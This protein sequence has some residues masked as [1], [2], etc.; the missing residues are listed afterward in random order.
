MVRRAATRTCLRIRNRG[1]GLV[2]FV[3]VAPTLLA[4][5]MAALQYGMVFHARFSLN[6]AAFEGARAAALDHASIASIERALAR[7]LTPYFGGGDQPAALAAAAAR[8][9]ADVAGAIRIEILSPTRESFDDYHS[10]DAARRAGTRARTIP[11][12]S[13]P[14]RSCPP[15]RPGCNANPAHNASGQTLA[16]ANLLKLRITWGIPPQKQMPLAGRFFVWALRTLDPAGND[17]FRLGLLGAGRIPVVAHA[18]VRMHSDPIENAAMASLR[19]RAGAGTPGAPA[20]GSG[21]GGQ[22]GADATPLPGCPAWEPLCAPAPAGAGGSAG[23][24]PAGGGQGPPD[25][26]SPIC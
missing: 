9:R 6:Y 18:T 22:P 26:G 3:L 20:P 1:A 25:D 16:D 8:A 10:P 5:T 4:M 13:L 14:F 24:P 2:E 17:D 12:A 15:D 7:A 11:S 21:A 23:N 19:A